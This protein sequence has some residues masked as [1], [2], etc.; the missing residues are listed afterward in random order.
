MSAYEHW[1]GDESVTLPEA[2]GNAFDVV[3]AGLQRA[4][5]HDDTDHLVHTL[6]SQGRFCGGSGSPMYD[7]LFELVA[8]DVEAGGVFATI[9]SGHEDDPSRHAVP[10]RLLGGLHRLVLDGRA[11]ALRR[12]YPSTG[13]T[14]DAEAAWPEIVLTATEPRPTRCARPSISRRRPTRWADPPR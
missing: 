4:R 3:G 5:T 14:W 13:G 11:P 6:R 8:D 9:L 1:L 2:L 10:L 12:W 7:E